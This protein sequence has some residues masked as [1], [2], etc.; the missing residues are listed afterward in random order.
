MTWVLRAV[1]Y[2]FSPSHPKPIHLVTNLDN[3]A[4]AWTELMS[5][6]EIGLANTQ[7]IG[8]ILPRVVTYSTRSTKHEFEL[9][10]TCLFFATRSHGWECAEIAV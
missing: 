8:T 9:V 4:A 6:F 5:R 10:S 7:K 2:I 3:V 1:V